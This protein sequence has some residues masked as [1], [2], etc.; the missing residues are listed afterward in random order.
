MGV[1]PRTSLLDSDVPMEDRLYG[2][3]RL[4]DP[5][6]AIPDKDEWFVCNK[7]EM[8]QMIETGKTTIQTIPRPPEPFK[9]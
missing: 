1:S 3:H 8:G 7:S 9:G 6:I 4:D 2:Y 5:K